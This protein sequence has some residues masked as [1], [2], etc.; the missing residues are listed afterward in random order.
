MASTGYDPAYNQSALVPSSVRNVDY[1]AALTT[2]T[3]NGLRIGV[4]NGF[5]NFSKDPEVAPV[6]KAMESMLRDLEAAGGTLVPVDEEIYNATAIQA[7]LDV[8]R[9]EFRELMDIYLQD[10][11]LSGEHPKTLN[12]LYSRKTTDSSAGEFLVLPSGYEYVNTALVSS[13]ANESYIER[14]HGIRNLTLALESTF[15]NHN[16]DA[17]IY[18][19][20]K[21]LV[22][23]VGSPSQSGRNGILAALTGV[24]VVTVPAGFS[25]PSKE[26][27]VGVPI[28]MEILGRHWSDEKLLQ[29][30]YQIEKLR[31]IRKSPVWAR[32]EVKVKNY[33]E[34]PVITPNRNNIPSAYPLGTL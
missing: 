18:P 17:I 7:K 25:E 16:L 27:P 21:N 26:A 29:I 19:E 28:G 4:L 34:V 9:F 2:G 31:H 15:A 22:V 12:E 5:F 6:N 24:P 8:Q 20:Q 23:K 1:A 30:A 13:T 33:K 14:Q 3:L 32:E 10:P 11:A